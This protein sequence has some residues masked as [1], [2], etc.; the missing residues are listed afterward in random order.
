MNDNNYCYADDGIIEDHISGPSELPLTITFVLTFLQQIRPKCDLQALG[1][2][3]GLTNHDIDE[4]ERKRH[5]LEQLVNICLQRGF[6][7]WEQV[8]AI[9]KELAIEQDE[10]IIQTEIGQ[11]CGEDS[12]PATPCVTS[13]TQAS[14]SISPDIRSVALPIQNGM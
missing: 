4:M 13:E 6:Q 14:P 12:Q 8:M 7:N 10:A 2:Q 5:D 9:L 11:Q 1:S 3:L